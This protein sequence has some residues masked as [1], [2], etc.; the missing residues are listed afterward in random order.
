MIISCNTQEKKEVL[1]LQIEEPIMKLSLTEKDFFTSSNVNFSKKG[2]SFSYSR[3]PGYIK[4]DS[5]NV[6]AK[7]GFNLS[8][9]FL[10]SGENAAKEQMLF[11]VYDKRTPTN[12][13]NFWIAGRRL[14]QR[15]NT[16]SLWAKEYDYSMGASGDY[17]DLF[18]LE[19]GKFYFLSVNIFDNKVEVFINSEL[20][21]R[22]DNLTNASLN[23]DELYL[24]SAKSGNGNFQFQY[25][26]YIRNLTI[27][28]KRLNALEIKT[29]SKENYLEIFPYN[30]AFELSKFN[31]E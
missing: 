31:L 11:S 14:T 10:L 28:N 24:G 21:A 26:G 18:E 15:V 19:L 22:Y 2:A 20:Y 6:D 27:F 17:Y 7:N 23:Y 3:S 16:N 1:S 9:W 25:D 12:S 29:L 4:I 13:I 5:L 30:D 8:C